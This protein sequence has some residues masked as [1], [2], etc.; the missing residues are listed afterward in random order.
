LKDLI[1][2][3]LNVKDMNFTDDPL[4]FQ[5][6]IFSP[7]FKQLGPK[8]KNDANTVAT[9]MRSQK[10]QKAKEIADQITQEGSY[11]ITIE[12]N[13][14]EINKDD[15]EIKITE[16]EGYSGASF[17]L[18]D[19]FLNLDLTEDL[20]NEGFVRDLIRRIQSMRKDME[21]EYDAEITVNFSK[22]DTKI[23]EIINNYSTLIKEEVLALKLDFL[24]SQEGFT[25]EWNIQ[26][27]HDNIR[28]I[29]INIQK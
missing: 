22:T 9:W 15:L 18:G 25:K 27:P 12:K 19:L 2:Q 20:I 17:S 24:A 14:F 1:L 21:L 5:E 13:A 4:E 29:T 8:F 23:I 26:D 28:Q 6:I 10:G 16:R 11:Q 7:N 3:E